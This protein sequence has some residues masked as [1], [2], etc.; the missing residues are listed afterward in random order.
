MRLEEHAPCSHVSWYEAEAWCNWAD[1]RL[2]TE[3]EWEVAASAEPDPTTGGLA[4]A[5]RRYPWGDAP[6]T[7]ERANLDWRSMGCVDVSAH[8]EGDSAFGCRQM[9]GNVWEWTASDFYPYPGFVVDRPYMQYSAPWFGYHKV[10]RGGA[11]ATR[12]RLVTN[13]YRNFYRPHRIDVLAGFRTC[14]R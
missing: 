9:L 2:P 6:P 8:P 3:A 5:K 4:G 7:A 11:W 12:G 10:L 1:R 14:A 13:T